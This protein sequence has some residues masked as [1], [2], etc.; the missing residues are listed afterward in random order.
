MTF[1]IA[2][3]SKLLTKIAEVAHA[4]HKSTNTI[5]QLI[6]SVRQ[7]GAGTQKQ[8]D[9]LKQATELQDTVN[10]EMDE[11]L[12]LIRSVLENIQK[13]LKTWAVIT[14]V[15]G[16]LALIALILAIVK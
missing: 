1:P 13:S 7:P 12:K 11:Q 2:S 9:D 3:I 10:K 16:S 15:I 14:A 5:R 8:L 4:T 6:D